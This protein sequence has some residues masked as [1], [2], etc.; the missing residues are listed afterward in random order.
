MLPTPSAQWPSIVL[1]FVLLTLATQRKPNL[2][3]NGFFGMCVFVWQLMAIQALPRAGSE[4]YTQQKI[5]L[6]QL[7]G[8]IFAF[9]FL[10]YKSWPLDAAEQ[11]TE[12]ATGTNQ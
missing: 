3:F 2:W 1:I 5:G 6:L 8:F 10:S 9:A 12:S 4:L 11:E 7:Y